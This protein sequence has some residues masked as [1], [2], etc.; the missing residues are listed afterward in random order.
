MP[1]KS[2]FTVRSGSWQSCNA[3]IQFYQTFRH[4]AP[5]PQE[6]MPEPHLRHFAYTTSNWLGLITCTESLLIL[7]KRLAVPA[8]AAHPEPQT[9]AVAVPDVDFRCVPAHPYR[10]QAVAEAPPLHDRFHVLPHAQ[11]GAIRIKALN[12]PAEPV[13]EVLLKVPVGI[14]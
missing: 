4:T 11:R 12:E 13:P 14:A 3:W 1:I 5:H 7:W 6:P 10:L 2:K 8:L 9:V